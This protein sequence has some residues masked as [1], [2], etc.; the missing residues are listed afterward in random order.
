MHLED[1][2]IEGP[3]A[4]G[5]TEVIRRYGALEP[6]GILS[7]L[8]VLLL[9]CFSRSLASV[10]AVPLHG[11]DQ[12]RIHSISLALSSFGFLIAGYGAVFL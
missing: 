8:L 7:L 2:R 3:G 12:M 9:L 11:H 10:A 5:A 4:A 6:L 1:G